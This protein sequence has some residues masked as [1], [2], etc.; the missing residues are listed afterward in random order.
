LELRQRTRR[1]WPALAGRWQS[2]ADD[3]LARPSVDLLCTWQDAGVVLVRNARRGDA[4]ITAQHGRLSYRPQTGDPLG[5]GAELDALDADE[6]HAVCA[7]TDYPDALAQ[8]ADIGRASRSGDLILS[9]A[10]G[11]DF[12]GRYEPIPHRS[13]HGA[14]HREHMLVP[15]VM[16]HAPSRTPRR[17]ADIMPSALA[18]LG[19]P[20][21][22]GLDGV[23]VN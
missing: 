9:A 5:L 1:P 4:L 8:L 6:A 22:D 16:N 3:L 14:L 2:V 18:A 23:R 19:L 13:T 7:A 11:Y 12:R 10:P 17:T 20:I 15:W 21:P